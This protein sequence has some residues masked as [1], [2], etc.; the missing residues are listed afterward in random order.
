MTPSDAHLG[1]LE[2]S[3]YIPSRHLPAGATY[4][5][6][7]PTKGNVHTGHRGRMLIQKQHKMLSLMLS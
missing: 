5:L 6:L 3:V 1:S 7:T 2:E 4:P